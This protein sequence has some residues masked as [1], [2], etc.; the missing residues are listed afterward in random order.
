MKFPYRELQDAYIAGFVDGEGYI[1]IY[2]NGKDKRGNH[3]FNARVIVGQ[4]NPEVLELIS[5]QYGGKV[6]KSIDKRTSREYYR[7]DVSGKRAEALL[8]DIQPYAIEK[9]EQIILALEARE[10]LTRTEPVKYSSIH[11]ALSE[12]KN[13]IKRL[14]SPMGFGRVKPVRGDSHH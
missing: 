13:K 10:I 12:I 6:Y 2:Q 3:Y 5:N 9:R 4:K 8:K 11:A 7:L 1:G 14:N